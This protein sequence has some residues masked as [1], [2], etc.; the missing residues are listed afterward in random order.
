M[1]DQIIITFRCLSFGV[2][3]PFA[4]RC[5]SRRDI[6]SFQ[7]SQ[8]T[9]RWR[10]TFD[11]RSRRH[12][13]VSI[14]SKKTHAINCRLFVNHYQFEMSH[15]RWGRWKGDRTHTSTSS[16]ICRRLSF[17]RCSLKCVTKI[18]IKWASVYTKSQKKKSNTSNVCMFA[19]NS[20]RSR[21]HSRSCSRSRSRVIRKYCK[22]CTVTRMFWY[23]YFRAI[24]SISNFVN[25]KSDVSD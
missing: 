13:K 9:I 22:V 25:F 10:I 15:D 7:F 6:R 1:F 23:F 19:L 2:H 8:I 14:D 3:L 21:R 17:A 5:S 4:E 12:K 11:R 20:S 18:K 24:S 16:R